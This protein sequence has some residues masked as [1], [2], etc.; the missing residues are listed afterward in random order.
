[1]G[2]FEGVEGDLDVGIHDYAA[3]DVVCSCGAG[4]G[5]TGSAVWGGG[6]ELGCFLDVDEGEDC[7]YCIEFFENRQEVSVVLNGVLKGCFCG[8]GSGEG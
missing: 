5:I 8:L 4:G 2:D 3:V 1:M 7:S 6:G